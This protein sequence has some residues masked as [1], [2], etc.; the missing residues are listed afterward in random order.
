[1]GWH[2]SL[3]TAR[4]LR[5]QDLRNSYP[6]HHALHPSPTHTHSDATAVRN[7]EA[8]KRDMKIADACIAKAAA[9]AAIA[10]GVSGGG[11][12][13]RVCVLEDVCAGGKCSKR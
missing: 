8:Y 10:T 11:G 7:T 1:M 3:G 9:A 6:A 2:F 13:L 12:L 4:T 5:C